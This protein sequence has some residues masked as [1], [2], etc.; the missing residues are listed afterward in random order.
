M[1]TKIII[2]AA[3]VLNSFGSSKPLHLNHKQFTR[4][5]HPTPGKILAKHSKHRQPADVA[6]AHHHIKSLTIE[7]GPPYPFPSNCSI[8][9]ETERCASF[10]GAAPATASEFF[11]Q[12]P[13]KCNWAEASYG[14]CQTK[15]FLAPAPRRNYYFLGNS[16]TRHYAFAL[17]D[18]LSKRHDGQVTNSDRINEKQACRRG[19]VSSCSLHV[20]ADNGTVSSTIEFMWKNYLGEEASSDD[21]DRDICNLPGIKTKD[22]F[23]ERFADA[24]SKDVLV[25]GSIPCNTSFFLSNGGRSTQGFHISAPEHALA[26]KHANMSTLALLLLQSFPGPIIWMSYA[27]LDWKLNSFAAKI[28]VNECFEYIDSRMKCALSQF[29]R[30]R[31]MDNRLLQKHYIS[32]FNLCKQNCT[33]PYLDIIHHPGAISE[34]ITR[35]ILLMLS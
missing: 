35:S 7:A 17:R 22:C 15:E 16:V 6:G 13:D 18:I 19:G 23:E 34:A 2:H 4:T 20:Y 10:R 31:F 9:F 29:D 12:V 28:D 1:S 27:H 24:T 8:E 26:S 32:N 30:I 21:L 14:P 25:V 11:S 5:Q 33:A 3:F